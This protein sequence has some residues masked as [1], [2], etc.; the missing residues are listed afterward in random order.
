MSEGELSS[1]KSD[2]N[3]VSIGLLSAKL[4]MAGT[5]SGMESLNRAIESLNESMKKLPAWE[6]S[7]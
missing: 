2:A 4:A 3:G 6:F 7:L 1:I 5:T